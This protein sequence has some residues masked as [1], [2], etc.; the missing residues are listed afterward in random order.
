MTAAEITRNLHGRKSGA[1]WMARCPA[2]DDHNP[3]L[4]LR[5]VDGKVLIRCHAGCD[6][7][8]VLDALKARGLW[9]GRTRNAPRSIVATYDYTDERGRLLYQVVRYEPKGFAQRRPDG[10]GG[11]IWGK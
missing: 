6:Q 1:G 8:A 11:W 2:H 3:S 5:D 10:R 4:S 9:L 7:R